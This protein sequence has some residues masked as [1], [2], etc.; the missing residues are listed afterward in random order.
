MAFM[1][2]LGVLSLLAIIV[3]PALLGAFV[4]APM[5]LYFEKSPQSETS[6]P[7]AAQRGARENLNSTGHDF[8]VVMVRFARALD[9]TYFP[10][11]AEKRLKY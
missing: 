11:V 6:N 5:Q 9:D 1:E 8:S 4:W 7:V 2:T 3:V 10:Q